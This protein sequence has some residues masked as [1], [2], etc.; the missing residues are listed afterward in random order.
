MIKI[1][2]NNRCSKSRCGLQILEESGKDF[3]VI[4]YLETPPTFDDLK[5]IINKLGIAPIN[6]VRKN[7]AIWK[8]S[9]KGKN[10]TDD[11]IIQA[12]IDHP[13]LIERPI[14]INGSK[15]VVGRPPE[16]ILDLI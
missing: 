6:L 16:T 12:M 3:E 9:F 8:G 7:E 15:A 13:K 5:S 10:L 2:H 4:K 14:V 11:Q 1:Y